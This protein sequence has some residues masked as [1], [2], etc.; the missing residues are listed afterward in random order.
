MQGYLVEHHQ[1]ESADEHGVSRLVDLQLTTAEDKINCKTIRNFS[2]RFSTSSQQTQNTRR[3]SSQ[4]CPGPRAPGAHT[5]GGS[6]PVLSRRRTPGAGAARHVPVH[7]LQELSPVGLNQFSAA[8]ER[9]AH[10]SQTCPTSTSSGSTHPGGSLPVLSRQNTRRWSSQTCPS[11]R[12]PGA[13]T[14][15]VLDQFSADAEHPAHSSQTRPTTTSSG[16]PATLKNTPKE[17]TD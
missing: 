11:P 3:K 8:A 7:E 9:P 1:Q 14:Q 4:T 15:A 5:P 10:G 16:S 17:G 2:G 13:H 12:A 6:R